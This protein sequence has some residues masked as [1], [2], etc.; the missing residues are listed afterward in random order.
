MSE[1]VR[2]AEIDLGR[3]QSA[4]EHEASPDAQGAVHPDANPDGFAPPDEVDWND[5]FSAEEEEELVSLSSGPSYKP[6]DEEL[7]EATDDPD[8]HP[9]EPEQEGAPKPDH[10]ELKEE[11]S[12]DPRFEFNGMVERWPHLMDVFYAIMMA[13]DTNDVE[14]IGE[15]KIA[16]ATLRCAEG[17]NRWYVDDMIQGQFFVQH[18]PSMNHPLSVCV[19]ELG[20]YVVWV[21][22]S[23]EVEDF[24]SEPVG[25]IHNGSV[26]RRPQVWQKA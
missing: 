16:L 24:P 6:T 4:Y 14:E 25:Y 3:A 8:F 2:C 15:D 18:D 22:K 19:K 1:Y 9:D 10:F 13:K 26:F 5:V 20:D 17:D 12:L 7:K 21:Y 11:P 23:G